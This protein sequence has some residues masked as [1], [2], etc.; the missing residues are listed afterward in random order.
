VEYLL[1]ALPRILGITPGVRSTVDAVAH[2]TAY[3]VL[4][5]FCRH[6]TLVP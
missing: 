5:P 1:S 3:W 4:W 6:R 2:G